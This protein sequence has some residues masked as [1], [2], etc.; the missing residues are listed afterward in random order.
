MKR[1]WL[2]KTK[3]TAL[4]IIISANVTVMTTNNAQASGVP[5]VDV[6]HINESI[7]QYLQML[8]DYQKYV[9]QYE[10][11]IE[12][13]ELMKL[14]YEEVRGI[15]TIG[16]A[17]NFFLDSGRVAAFPREAPSAVYAVPE[18]EIDEVFKTDGKAK[19]NHKIN[20]DFIFGNIEKIN[21]MYI[22][23][24][25]RRETLIE[26][27]GKIAEAFWP[28]AIWDLNTRVNAENALLNND[29]AQIQILKLSIEMAERAII[30]N[31]SA[32]RITDIGGLED[33]K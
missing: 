11:M 22:T 20:E 10:N 13:L 27:R 14:T 25:E 1:N 6:V 17:L 5:V 21:A 24:D 32:R 16:E 3:S 28:K 2:N 29:I 15:T 7:L 33:V 12:R 4:A 30:H 19:L 23:I 9:E 8:E 18:F 31:S 26:L